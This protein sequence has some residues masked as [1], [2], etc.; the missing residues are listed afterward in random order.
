MQLQVH[1]EYGKIKNHGIVTV[2]SLLPF[3]VFSLLG[4]P[5]NGPRCLKAQEVGVVFLE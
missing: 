3:L 1:F 2:V 5:A 4:N